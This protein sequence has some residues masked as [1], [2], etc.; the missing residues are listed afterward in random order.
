MALVVKNPPANAGD[1]RDTGSISGSGRSPGGGN[2]NP[3]QYSCLE[4]PTDRGAWQALVHR[5]TKSQTQLKWLSM[6]ARFFI[7]SSIDGHLGRLPVL[8][9]VNNAAFNMELQICFLIFPFPLDK[10]PEVELLDYM[11]V[12]VLRNLH[13]AFHSGYTNLHPH[14]Q[15][16][17]A[18]FLL[19]LTHTSFLL[20]TTILTSV[21]SHCGFDLYFQQ[22][23]KFLNI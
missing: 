15:W 6:T 14:Q 1:I 21:I 13:T 12:L 5:I 7:H 18:S 10:Y 22:F 23:L 2:G 19:M 16:T 9:I 11:A 4:K 8:G 3:L 17:R 20:I